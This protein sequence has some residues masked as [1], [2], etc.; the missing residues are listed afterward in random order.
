MSHRRTFLPVFFLVCLSLGIL[1]VPGWATT[2]KT[3]EVSCP[4][5]GGTVEGRVIMSTNSFGGG[6]FD[7]CPRPRGTPTVP[8]AIWGCPACGF[9]G[10]HA[11]FTA[12]MTAVDREDIRTWLSR[13]IGNASPPQTPWEK[14]D[15]KA[16][17]ESFRKSSPENVAWLFLKAAWCCRFQSGTCFVPPQGTDLEREQRKQRF[18]F[19]LN[20]L[21]TSLR[22]IIS[23][24]PPAI[25]EIEMA[26]AAGDLVKRGN[27]EP[28]LRNDAALLA[29]QFYRTHGEHASTLQWLEVLGTLDPEPRTASLVASI[30]Q[31]IELEKKYQALAVDQLLLAI[32]MTASSDTRLKLETIVAETC[33]RIERRPE[34]ENRF[35]SILG[36]PSIPEEI[37]IISVQGLRL[38]G[39]A[40]PRSP[41]QRAEM[42]KRRRERDLRDLLDPAR[43]Q[44][45][46]YSLSRTPDPSIIP[47]LLKILETADIQVQSHVLSCL[48]YDDPRV[49]KALLERV[50]VPGLHWAAQNKLSQIAN[51][52]VVPDLVAKLKNLPFVEENAT[53]SYS[54][55]EPWT[56]IGRILGTIGGPEATSFL[57]QKGMEAMMAWPLLEEIPD[58]DQQSP[59][60][61]HI[62]VCEAIAQFLGNCDDAKVIKPL[63][64]ALI[65]KHP[66]LRG[67]A[68]E[69]LEK[70]SNRYFGFSKMEKP[71]D[72]SNEK[73]ALPFEQAMK[74]WKE[75]YAAHH[76][77]SR[78]TWVQT[79]FSAEGFNVF[80]ASDP[81]KLPALIDTLNDT[82]L[83]IRYN[84]YMELVRRTGFHPG[85]ESIRGVDA[86]IDFYYAAN[87]FRSWL[88]N[89][90]TSLSWDAARARF[91]ITLPDPSQGKREGR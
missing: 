72:P 15:L 84:G 64:R 13:Q 82:R 69:S 81:E 85:Y 7:F 52:A 4:I 39:I 58:S 71:G 47:D 6:D 87:E 16:R 73:P 40:D 60:R 41:E 51:P 10:Y 32:P 74:A 54:L 9:P 59:N 14:Y 83:N 8:L 68:G 31:G 66:Y 61:R 86:P 50:D 88:K 21:E 34:A 29:A 76:E 3:E 5:C 12:S 33:R 20:R 55:G 11:D 35:K 24:V 45:A 79:G 80:P 1:L 56:D 42:K 27:L 36:N 75:W 43:S 89:N 22:D 46:A 57:A 30:R 2:T 70:L 23:E 19:L 28:A 48:E 38:M 53:E 25:L 63:S 90:R 77:E 49:L 44:Q 18:D 26:S 91:S 78:E 37:E 65:S 67:C 17:L 62:R